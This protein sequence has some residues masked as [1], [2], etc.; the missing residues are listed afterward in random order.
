MNATHSADISSADNKKLIV[1]EFLKEEWD[2]SPKNSGDVLI[3]ISGERA[4]MLMRMTGLDYYQL[5]RVL[6]SFKEDGLI[7]RHEFINPAM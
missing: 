1:L 2:L 4:A 7:M 3:K 6:E 5:D